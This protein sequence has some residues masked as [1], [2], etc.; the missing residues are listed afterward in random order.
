MIDL[1]DGD[2]HRLVFFTVD[3]A[4]GPLQRIADWEFD[5]GEDEEEGSEESET[6]RI[7]CGEASPPGSCLEIVTD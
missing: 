7:G 6:A 4:G 2:S 3:A 1:E 5:P